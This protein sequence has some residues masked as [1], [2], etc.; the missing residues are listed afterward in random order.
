MAS[1]E[2]PREWKCKSHYRSATQPQSGWYYLRAHREEP[3]KVTE[4]TSNM[5]LAFCKAISL[6]L[7]SEE[8]TRSDTAYCLL[9]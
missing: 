6:Y 2:L 1:L 3:W 5:A 9:A 7:P 8:D 4:A